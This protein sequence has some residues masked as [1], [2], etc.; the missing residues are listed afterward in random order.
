MHSVRI[1]GNIELSVVGGNCIVPFIKQC[2]KLVPQIALFKGGPIF[3]HLTGNVVN[4]H[5]LDGNGL[6]RVEKSAFSPCLPCLKSR[7]AQPGIRTGTGGFGVQKNK[8]NF[9]FLIQLS[10]SGLSDRQFVL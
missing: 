2:P 3:D 4:G 10:G 1:N 9:I 7:L 6:C 5:G 8:Q